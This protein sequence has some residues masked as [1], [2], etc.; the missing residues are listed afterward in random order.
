VNA[1]ARK[2]GEHSLH[3]NHP[4]LRTPV[5]R[6]AFW[7]PPNVER[8]HPEKRRER[9][10]AVERVKMNKHE[11]ETEENTMRGPRRE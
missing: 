10:G 2:K 5:P 8:R 9:T 7:V 11:L 1:A 4:K 6:S 3:T